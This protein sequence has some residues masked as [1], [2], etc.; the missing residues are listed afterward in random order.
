MEASNIFTYGFGAT[1][2]FG[3][4]MLVIKYATSGDMSK[5]FNIFKKQQEEN[6]T[7]LDNIEH[8]QVKLTEDLESAKKDSEKSRE[9]TDTIIKNTIDESK[10]SQGKTIQET[11]KEIEEDLKGI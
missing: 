11:S 6:K 2:L 1:V 7:K 9:R 8:D 3:G 10:T 5:L 4:L